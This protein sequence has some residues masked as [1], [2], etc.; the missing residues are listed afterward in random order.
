MYLVTVRKMNQNDSGVRSS[1]LFIAPFLIATG[2]LSAAQAEA[3]ARPIAADRV[4]E[5]SLPYVVKASDT[6]I[7]LSRE[8]LVGGYSWNDV[9][10]YNRLKNPNLIFPDQK[11]D[12]P[13]RFLRFSAAGGKVISAEGNATLNGS[14]VQPG[15]VINAGGQLK[16]GANSSMVIEVG[17]GSRIKVLPNSLAEVV[18][19][20]SYTMRDAS[21]SGSTNW[22]SGLMRLSTGALEALAAKSVN[23]ATP[24]QVE[25]PTSLVGVRGTKFR[26]AYDDPIG[27][28]ARTEVIEGNVRTD[29][30]AQQTGADLPSGTGAV[31]RP[32]EREIRVVQLL[33]APDLTTVPAEIL[34]PVGAWPMPVLAGA[35]AYRVQVASDES[36]NNVV[37]DLKVST[38]NVDL[39]SLA[40]GNW[41]ARV[42]GIDA[43]GLE[44]FDT[45]KLVVVKDGQWRAVNS[46]MALVNGRAILRWSSQQS[47]GQPMPVSGYSAVLA[48]NQALTQVVS[49]AEGSTSQLDLGNLQPGVYFIRLRSKPR[50]EAGMD[51]ETYRLEV[52]TNWGSSVFELL[53]ALQ[54]LN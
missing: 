21:A 19:N 48:R 3:P 34:K 36:F 46:S 15:T 38:G 4:T 20:R 1:W 40:N 53:S 12:I 10:R 23:R 26:V 43:Q 5:P 14:A 39:A 37:R 17:D 29:N 50:G 49:S 9:A 22:F 35:Q 54:P 11:I 6:L 31:V 18:T 2:T 32:T 30:P 41:F 8:L 44:G 13:L 47:N 45:I 16:T 25:T 42:R 52:S 7:H 28:S 24:L 27:K 51:S 33:A